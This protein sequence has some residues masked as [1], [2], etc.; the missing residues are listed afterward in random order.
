MTGEEY[1]E[2][3]QMATHTKPDPITDSHKG[4]FFSLF[5]RDF[6]YANR[7]SIDRSY[8]QEID[9]LKSFTLPTA[10]ESEATYPFLYEQLC[11]VF[12]EGKKREILRSNLELPTIGTAELRTINAFANVSYNTII[13][14]RNLLFFLSNM[15]RVFVNLLVTKEEDNYLIRPIILTS[16]EIQKRILSNMDIN[17]DFIEIMTSYAKFGTV[18]PFSRFN[19]L[20]HIDKVQWT[21]YITK[22][23]IQF[24]IAHELM[25]LSYMH[26]ESTVK[27]ENYADFWATQL[28]VLSA[29]NA[30]KSMKLCWVPVLA[31][32]ILDVLAE[33]RK[34]KNLY[35][36][37]FIQKQ[38]HP[39]DRAEYAHYVIGCMDVYETSLLMAQAIRRTMFL[40]W[41]RTKKSIIGLAKDERI[42]SPEMLKKVVSY[43]GSFNQ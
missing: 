43:I 26:T 28:C 36:K 9:H 24:V 22:Y 31:T 3:I 6:G 20:A 37:E 13:V 40:L 18:I 10:Y 7:E 1:L 30:D 39:E 8:D 2:R 42:D 25:H 32:S 33:C 27:N 38:T 16:E 21:E 34:E 12:N 23:V 15:V 41:S 17:R 19:A 14:D 5:E 35:S 29:D 11:L 4:L